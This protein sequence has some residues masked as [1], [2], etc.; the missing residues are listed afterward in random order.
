MKDVICVGSTT[1]DVFVE[2]GLK[3]KNGNVSYPVGSKILVND[4]EV[5]TGGGGGNTAVGFSRMG[6]RTGLVSN[7]GEG[8]NADKIL[9]VLKKEGVEFLGK[10]GKGL[11]GYSVILDSSGRDRTIL[12][13]KGANDDIGYSDLD[14]GKIKTKW[15]YLSSMLGKS[16]EMQKKLVK[17]ARRNNV[18]VA[19]NIS[20]YLAKKG[21][22]YLK[23]MLSSCDVLILNKEESEMLVGKK[24]TLDKLG[25]VVD[26]VC[27]TDGPHGAVAYAK[28]PN[29]TLD[30]SKFKKQQE[31]REDGLSNWEIKT[32]GAKCV[33]ATGAGDA[34]ACG[35]VSALVKGESIERGLKIGAVNAES[36]IAH[37]GAKN[38]L[39]SWREAVGDVR[40]KGFVVKKE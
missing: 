28:V 26:V 23:P 31:L 39:L 20:G 32:S 25:K 24:A 16:F 5:Y 1:I 13:Y 27:V 14:I 9:K 18:K 33:E 40:R 3:E 21:L 30:T 37:K 6:L 10:M 35:F 4:L 2:T 36:V 7:V 29:V 12:T 11:S 34:F 17:W 15:L 19:Y 8:E 22:A 38:K